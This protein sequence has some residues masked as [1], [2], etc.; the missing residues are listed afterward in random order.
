MPASC[1]LVCFAIPRLH[2]EIPKCSRSGGSRQNR[3]GWDHF[4]LPVRLPVWETQRMAGDEVIIICEPASTQ[5]GGS[6][7][8]Q[9]D[10]RRA[11]GPSEPADGGHNEQPF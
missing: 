1:A 11:V 4:V 10:A 5:N 6:D 3:K 7:D 9:P 8:P 2:I